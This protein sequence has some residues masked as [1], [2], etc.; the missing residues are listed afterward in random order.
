[1]KIA[2]LLTNAYQV[3]H[4]RH[5]VPWLPSPPT[6]LVEVRDED[7]GVD[8]E[9]VAEHLPGLEVDWV[10]ST[11]LATI[12]GR[13]D[14]IVCQTPVLPMRFL[15][16]SRTV[17]L[18]YSLAKERYQYG[19]WRSHVDL[20][21]MY[22]PYSLQQVERFCHARAVGNL[23]FSNLPAGALQVPPATLRPRV[24]VL[25]TYGSLSA[26]ESVL[27][28]LDTA[29]LDV[30]V[31]LHHREPMEVRSRV[32]RGVRLVPPSADPMALILDADLVVSDFSGAAFDAAFCRRP[33]LLTGQVEEGVGDGARLSRND[34]ER[35]HLADL[36]VEWMADRSFE[37]AVELAFARAS[38]GAAYDRFVNRFFVNVGRAAEAAAAAIVEAPSVSRT[39]H[40]LGG[41]IDEALARHVVANRQLRAKDQSLTRERERHG[42]RRSGRLR[43]PF[44][45][46]GFAKQ[47]L[48]ELVQRVARASPTVG[49]AVNRLI[50][51]RRRRSLRRRI[52]K[53]PMGTVDGSAARNPTTDVSLRATATSGGG[54]AP[55]PRDLAAE[56][57]L[58]LEAQRVKLVPSPLAPGHFA[59]YARQRVQLHRALRDWP[60]DREALRLTLKLSESRRVRRTLG[61]LKRS[62]L[63]AAVSLEIVRLGEEVPVLGDGRLEL[64]FVE[65][66]DR[67]GRV[68]ALDR[69]AEHVDWTVDFAEVDDI[70]LDDAYRLKVIE[71]SVRS[72]GIARAGFSE[73]ID[74]VFTWVDSS[75]PA[76]RSRRASQRRGQQVVLESADN[77]ERYV[78]RDE[79]RFSLR[80]VE[81]FA[82]FVRNV[83]IVTDAQRPSWLAIDHPRVRVVDHAEIFP[84]PAVLPVFNSHAIEACL[85][86]IEGLAEHYLYMNDDFFFGNEVRPDDFFSPSG[87]MKVHLSPSQIVYDGVPRN[88]AIPTDWASYRVKRLI[89]AEYGHPVRHRLKH[90]AYPQ[91]RSIAAEVE[92]RYSELVA[93][94]RAARFRSNTD[95]AMPS[96]F[97]PYFA[98]AM[99]RAVAWPNSPGDY[100]YADTGRLNWFTR[101]KDILKRQPRFFCLNATRHQE[102]PL[103]EQAENVTAFLNAY[104][105]RPSTMELTE[106]EPSGAMGRGRP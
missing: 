86:R 90:Q 3:H 31:K 32:P 12:D 55:V 101:A 25:P 26:L 60:G 98:M 67:T 43:P 81:R 74:M 89:E 83:F 76:W 11:R 61:N 9:L 75:D 63:L 99:E 58:A 29:A 71:T 56:L 4:F 46:L 40:E 39:T 70:G 37:K 57:A 73:P 34:L 102:V 53:R 36:A 93:R 97:L 38:D 78:D 54:A 33:V 19:L 13:F 50:V 14:V 106:P 94:T 5:L 42:E 1:M 15:Q 82:P 51:M 17:A 6:V 91:R 105:P 52:A 16:R 92:R 20:N 80:A 68:M 41:M 69:R 79:L 10:P 59:V 62:G 45:D 22:G 100:V 77:E 66:D 47:R 7:F 88:N 8:E 87:V 49:R 65:M 21:L 35:S 2:L 85:H 28:R 18:Q 64:H 84:D 103:K 95:L 30:V 24:L 96:M 23:L 72:R 44:V 48:K 27:A 104:Y